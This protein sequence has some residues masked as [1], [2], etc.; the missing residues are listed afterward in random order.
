MQGPLHARLQPVLRRQQWLIV[1]KSAVTGLLVGSVAAAL[2]GLGKGLFAAPAPG[3]ALA[4][5]IV[6]GPVFGTMLGRLRRPDW[7]GAARAVD[8]H[9]H[10]K[11]RTTTALAFVARPPLSVFQEVEIADALKQ[12]GRI[13]PAEVVPLRLPR[14]FAAAVGVTAV[15]LAL[16]FW[17]GAAP[18]ASAAA[19]EAVPG[20]VAEAENIAEDLDDLEK[21]AREAGDEKLL[22]LVQ[23]L[24]KKVEAMKQ[25][26]VSL[27]DAMSTIS[28]IQSAI[29]A[30]AAELNT[31]L[32]D[33]KLRDLGQAM[34][35]AASLEK[36]A[37]ALQDGDYEKAAK[38]LENPGEPRF[39]GREAKAAG[40]KMNRISQD[41]RQAGLRR[42]GDA[43]KRMAAGMRGEK[44]EYREGA[45]ELAKEVRQQER[46]KRINELLARENSR[47]NECKNRSQQSYLEWLKQQGKGGKKEDKDS[48]NESQDAGQEKPQQA[49]GRGEKPGRDPRGNRTRLTPAR[50]EDKLPSQP[51]AGEEGERTIDGNGP[52]GTGRAMRPTREQYQKYRREVEAALEREPI[53]IGQREAIRRYFDLIHASTLTE[54]GGGTRKGGD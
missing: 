40:E 54:G 21:A 35:A 23:E 6:A 51:G 1:V 45:R 22:E 52:R 25:P 19:P 16:L 30:H 42:L 12:L 14:S 43:T 37:K 17:P 36:A 3:W 33:E 39:D 53:P 9:Y 18:D 8:E 31:Q 32:V 38:A 7:H 26:G 2:L 50:E 28:E 13:D 47:L 44:K 11:D 24:R 10:L 4:G 46:R 15:A 29:G 41:M 5:L 49:S 20:I 48:K 34:D 27:R